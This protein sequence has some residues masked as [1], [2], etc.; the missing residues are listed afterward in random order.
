MTASTVRVTDP[1]VRIGDIAPRTTYR[2]SV[3]TFAVHIIDSVGH[4]TL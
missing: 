4:V 3:E 1:I 2:A